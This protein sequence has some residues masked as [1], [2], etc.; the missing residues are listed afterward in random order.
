MPYIN[1]HLQRQPLFPGTGLP[2]LA[3]LLLFL[4][5]QHAAA[6]TIE[7]RAI[8]DRGEPLQKVSMCLV[9]SGTPDKCAKV[10][11]TDKKGKYSFTGLRPGGSYTVLV[12]GNRSASSRKFESYSNYAWAPRSVTADISTRNERVDGGDFI[13]KFNF[14]NFQ[15][16]VSLG[17]LDFPELAELDLAGSY[18]VLKVFIASSQEGVAPETIFLGQVRSGAQLEI[19]ASVPLSVT[20]IGYEIYSAVSSINGSIVLR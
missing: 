2:G 4:C 13:G 16:I 9:E 15:R 7:G 11:W 1:R 20:S 5:T 14:S 18:T 10:R 12:N 19:E 8:N 6:A 17:A 3:L